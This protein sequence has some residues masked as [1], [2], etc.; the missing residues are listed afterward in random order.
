MFDLPPHMQSLP[1]HMLETVCLSDSIVETVSNKTLFIVY[2]LHVE[3]S[4]SIMETVSNKTPFIV[5]GLHVEGQDLQGK[6]VAIYCNYY[7]YVVIVMFVY[8]CFICSCLITF[9]GC[10]YFMSSSSF[11]YIQAVV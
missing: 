4:D 3:G 5:Y 1:P 8:F 7:F 2:G 11:I 9:H 10:F 6:A